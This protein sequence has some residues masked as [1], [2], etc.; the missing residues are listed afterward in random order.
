MK[1]IALLATVL[2]LFTFQV[3]AQSDNESN[4]KELEVTE[5]GK[6]LEA[7]VIC[8]DAIEAPTKYNAFAK[9]FI[10]L[11]NFPKKGKLS[12]SKLKENIN[13][14]FI[15]NPNLID[16]VIS[17]RKKAHDKLYGKRPY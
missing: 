11:A 17:E 1:N 6:R 5:E 15:A 4:T 2:T 7:T 12:T 10:S 9:Q 14:Y 13:T 3:K 8:L 16:K